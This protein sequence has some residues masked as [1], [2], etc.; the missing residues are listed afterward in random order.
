MGH[1]YLLGGGGGGGG[2]LDIPNTT[3]P[4]TGMGGAVS[5]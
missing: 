4:I 3:Q 2:S 5:L 1:I